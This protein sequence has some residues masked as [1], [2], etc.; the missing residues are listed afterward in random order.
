MKHFILTLYSFFIFSSGFSQ[1]INSAK[2]SEDYRQM[3]KSQRIGGIILLAAGVTTL[4][5]AA[6][7]D[8][9]FDDLP[10]VLILG[11]LATVGGTTLLIASGKNEKKSRALSAHL[12]FKK[13]LL[14]GI[15]YTKPNPI[16][17]ISL[18]AKF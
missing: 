8:I 4:T 18:K 7:G 9:S 10:T 16:P 15:N 14:D 17:T 1:D 2:T 13:Q 11:G 6:Q 12:S 3:S 5:I